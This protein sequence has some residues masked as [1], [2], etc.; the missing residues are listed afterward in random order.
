MT[1]KQQTEALAIL[2]GVD[3]LAGLFSMDATRAGQALRDRLVALL[4]ELGAKR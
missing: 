3:R 4:S 1:P 2:M